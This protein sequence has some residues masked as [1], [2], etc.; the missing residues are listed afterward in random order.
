MKYIHEQ[1]A[2][3]GRILLIDDAAVLLQALSDALRIR[4]GDIHIDTCRSP[5]EPLKAASN[6]R[7]YQVIATDVRMPY[8][9][10]L[11][12]LRTVRK[13][14]P[15]IPVIVM[16]AYDEVSYIQEGV[17]AGAYAVVRKPFERD[18]IVRLFWQ[19]LMNSSHGN[20][21]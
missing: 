15:A 19:A 1:D 12:F 10:G 18:S 5:I 21:R 8:L 7:Q 14:I 4:L 17:R 3:H 2:V 9:D 20:C 16:T 13:H 6:L 11:S